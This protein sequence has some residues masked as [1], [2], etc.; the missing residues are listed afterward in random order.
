MYKIELNE[1]P[2]HL[3]DDY[4][5]LVS[6]SKIDISNL[7]K[8]LNTSGI[9]TGLVNEYLV[10]NDSSDFIS[11]LIKV[12]EDSK[13][14]KDKLDQVIEN[15]I[16]V[17]DTNKYIDIV[18]KYKSESSLK[19]DSSDRIY[20]YNDIKVLMRPIGN[21]MEVSIIV[22]FS[23]SRNFNEILYNSLNRLFEALYNC[24]INLKPMTNEY[25]SIVLRFEL[26]IN[27]L[28]AHGRK[29]FDIL[30]NQALSLMNLDKH[31]VLEMISDKVKSILNN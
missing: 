6:P 13:V 8:L 20:G 31:S 16:Y 17:C 28:E 15:D 11:I 7:D 25:D 24:E 1:L 26:P 21:N 9:I 18:K 27:A 14:H 3:G 10:I 2:D 23:G 19:F 5:I 12:D 30:M 4:L 22:P 29:N